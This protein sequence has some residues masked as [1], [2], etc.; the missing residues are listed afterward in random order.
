MAAALLR[1]SAAIWVPPHSVG[2]R[3]LAAEPSFV[4]MLPAPESRGGVRWARTSLEAMPSVKSAV[5]IF[6]ARD[7]TLIAAKVPP[8]SG[9]RL[10]R[11]LPNLVEDSLLQDAHACAFALGPRLGDDRRMVAVIDRGWLEFVVGAVGRRGVRVAAAWPAQLVL[12]VEPGRWAIGCVHDGL[13]LRTGEA[14]GFGWSASVDQA[15]RAE[16]LVAAA[17]AGMQSEGR[18]NAVAVYAEQPEWKASVEEAAK[19]IGVP[20]SFSGLSAPQP[21]SVDLLSAMQRGA[22]RRWLASFDWRSWR[23]PLALAAGCLAAWLIG[24]NLQ[25]GQLARERTQLRAQ[26]EQIFRQAF[27]KAQVVV[28]PLL[29]MQRQVADLRLN[30][31]Q[32]GPDD[33]LPML[34]RFSLAL[35]PRANDA[36]AGLEYRGGKLRV[37]FRGEFLDA[38]KARENLRAALQQRGLKVD[39]EGEGEAVAVVSLQT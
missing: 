2:E 8:L 24:L 33:F 3:A 39:F 37:R 38:P 28:D 21:A 5:L 34:A 27:P 35:G 10:Q 18:P 17:E 14:S 23:L 7:V 6:D 11:A 16:A 20:I 15:S 31:G 12:P 1:R 13:A 9:A 25:W 30:T 29:Q 32:S 22:G 4:V 19:R 36:L 26:M